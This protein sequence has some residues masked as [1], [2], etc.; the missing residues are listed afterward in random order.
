MPLQN[1]C[2]WWKNREKGSDF[3]IVNAR[4]LQNADVTEQWSSAS[5]NSG[6][7]ESSV[8]ILLKDVFVFF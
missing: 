6:F 4:I 8:L 3:C 2:S 1:Q 5:I 7:A